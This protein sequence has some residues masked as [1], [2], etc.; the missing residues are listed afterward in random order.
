M[1]SVRAQPEHAASSDRHLPE[2]TVSERQ[3]DSRSVQTHAVDP[4]QAAAVACQWEAV[5]LLA[6]ELQARRLAGVGNVMPAMSR[7][8]LP[9]GSP[10][11]TS[12]SSRAEGRSALAVHLFQAE[13]LA[14]ADGE[15]DLA[16]VLQ[17]ARAAVERGERG[18]LASR[19]EGGAAQR[20]RGRAKQ[21][22]GERST[23]FF[24]STGIITSTREPIDTRASV[25][26]L[27]RQLPWLADE[28]ASIAEAVAILARA[29]GLGLHE[30]AL[31][32]RLR[33]GP[34]RK[35]STPTARAFVRDALRAVGVTKERAKDTGRDVHAAMTRAS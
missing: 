24:A 27:L 7:R 17:R 16:L 30:P 3:D 28:H 10:S 14:R 11:T 13:A 6:A 20:V 12:R 31:R 32:H 18:I 35:L 5:S 2:K 9:W 1:S 4:V 34:W 21:S 8:R 23:S 29:Q 19:S 25:V 26:R 15:P 33:A 22:T